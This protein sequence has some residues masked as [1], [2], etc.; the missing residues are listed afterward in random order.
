MHIAIRFAP[1]RPAA[2]LA[3]ITLAW[4]AQLVACHSPGA[5]PVLAGELQPI[6]LP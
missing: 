1:R 4:G 3:L 5:T 6:Q 2:L